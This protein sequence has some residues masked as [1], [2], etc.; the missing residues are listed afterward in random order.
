MSPGRLGGV[1]AEGRLTVRPSAR[2]TVLSFS[3][4]RWARGEVM[5]AGATWNVY[6]LVGLN[7]RAPSRGEGKCWQVMKEEGAGCQ[8]SGSN[9]SESS[10]PGPNC[11]G[12]R[13]H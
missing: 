11:G 6:E 10:K 5:G 2:R 4:S 7:L 8:I 9:S 3:Q 13:R 1:A 12:T